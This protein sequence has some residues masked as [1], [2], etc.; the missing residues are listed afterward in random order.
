MLIVR[1]PCLANARA[2]WYSREYQEKIMPLRLNPSAGDYVVTVYPEIPLRADLAGKVETADYT[3]HFDANA[4][5]QAQTGEA[6]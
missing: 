6:P 2:F 4:I 1:F 5:E 3:A